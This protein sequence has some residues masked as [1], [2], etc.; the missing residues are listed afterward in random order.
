MVMPRTS[1]GI[2][3]TGCCLRAI[4]RQGSGT[5]DLLEESIRAH[6]EQARGGP[7]GLLLRQIDFGTE[8]ERGP[9]R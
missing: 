5:A 1:M 2:G 8:G 9:P 6:A 3:G 7:A 4:R